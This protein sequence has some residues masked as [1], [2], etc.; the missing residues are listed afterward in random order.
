MC[1]NCH[2]L[3][4]AFGERWQAGYKARGKLCCQVTLQQWFWRVDIALWVSIDTFGFHSTPQVT[5]KLTT[6]MVLIWRDVDARRKRK[7][8]ELCETYGTFVTHLYSPLGSLQE[9]LNKRNNSLQNK[10]KRQISSE[11]SGQLIHFNCILRPIILKCN[12]FPR[13]KCIS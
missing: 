11:R 8:R 3:L 10:T 4:Q 2:E 12:T 13:I 6:G 5:P 9:K 1:A 7:V